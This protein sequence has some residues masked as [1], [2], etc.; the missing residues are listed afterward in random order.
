MRETLITF[1]NSQGTWNATI[2]L[3]L[4]A[5]VGAIISVRYSINA[6]RPKL[7]ITGQ[8]SSGTQASQS[9]NITITNRPS[10]FGKSLDGETARE[11]NALIR[12]ND[13]KSTYYTL[14]W[15]IQK[16][17]RIT[18]EP[19]SQQTLE[20]FHWNSGTTGYFVGDNKGEPVAKFQSRELRFILTLRDILDRKTEI[21][22]VAD[23]DDTNLKFHPNLQIILPVTFGIRIDRIKNGIR[24]IISAFRRV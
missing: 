4:G 7:I 5:I 14:F 18:I 3:V 21:K 22:F 20:L 6:N 15:G 16:D 24:E 19:G 17:Y 12:L 8:G 10:F 11:V 13:R 23:F 1:L 9:W 2:F